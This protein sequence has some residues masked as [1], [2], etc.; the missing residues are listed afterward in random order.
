MV[1]TQQYSV[2]MIRSRTYRHYFLLFTSNITLTSIA[3]GLWVV[4]NSETIHNVDADP[5]GLVESKLIGLGEVRQSSLTS[6][7]GREGRVSA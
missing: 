1:L 7:D 6:L 5:P 2:Q 3:V 4:P